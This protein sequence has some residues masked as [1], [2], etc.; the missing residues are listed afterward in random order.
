MIDAVKGKRVPCAQQLNGRGAVY[1]PP[2]P[3]VF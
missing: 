3:V 1:Y 2:I